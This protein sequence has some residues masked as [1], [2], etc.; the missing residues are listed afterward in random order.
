MG[1]QGECIVAYLYP[2]IWFA[3]GLIMIFK[4][5]QEN[6]IFIFSGIYFI[7]LGA[8][9][10]VGVLHPEYKVFSGD[11]GWILRGLTAGALAVVGVAFYRETK[12]SA[13]LQKDAEG[14]Q[15]ALPEDVA[16]SD[17]EEEPGSR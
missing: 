1:M 11:L 5:R 4:L 3:A 2:I 16:Q 8:W 14:E 13:Q 6:K 10:L 7:F 15:P 9:W 17:E 12:R